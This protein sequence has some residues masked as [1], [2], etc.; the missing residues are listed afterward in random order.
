MLPESKAKIKVLH[1][2]DEPDIRDVTQL[3]L[4]L[5]GGLEV[6]SAPSAAAA[7]KMI[8]AFRPWVILLDVMMPE[9]DG[10]AFFRVLRDSPETAEIP[11]V[12]ITA[13]AH[14]GR[15]AEL[16]TLG[17]AGVIGKPF[18]PLSL[19]AELRA[20]LREAAVT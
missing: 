12:F 7:I 4:E 18:E 15:I 20:I 16:M 1:V 10:P 8:G 17:A 3:S 11:V 14:P 13:A 9:M 2:D 6:M 5:D 19:A